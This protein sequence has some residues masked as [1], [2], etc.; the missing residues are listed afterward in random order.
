[1]KHSLMRM[2]T[3]LLLLECQGCLV[4]PELKPL[5]TGSEPEALSEGW[6]ISSPEAEGLDP[7][8]IEEVYERL[9]SEDL[10][11][12]VRSLLIVRHGKLVAEGYSRDA[13]D[14]DRFQNLQS[15]TKSVTSLLVGIAREEGLVDSLETP[16]YAFLPEYFDEDP[17][18]RSITLRDVLTMRTGLKFRN[19][20]DSGP[21]VHSR[22]SSV[23]N[24]LQRPLEFDPGSNFYYNDGTPQLVAGLLWEVAGLTLEEYARDRLFEPLG[25]ED[26]QWERHRDGLSFG[27]YGL[28]LRPRDMAKIGQLMLQEGVW[29]GHRIVPP[30]WLE[31][32]T[33]IYANGDYGYYWWVMEEGRVYRASGAGGQIIFVD[34]GNDLVIVLTGD[35]ASKNWILSPGIN[36]LFTGI[37]G[38]IR[39]P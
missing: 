25:I 21:F 14:R 30:E 24:V 27:A 33:R 9:F 5:Y 15:A 13:R 32:S 19:E 28:W 26:Y 20:E 11:P 39:G 6:E 8:R 1:M 35:P 38:A 29:E 34:E 22:G 12:T 2:A 37:L 23:R 18:K 4:D 7:A 31:E 10:F 17:R 36:S 16:L 3:F